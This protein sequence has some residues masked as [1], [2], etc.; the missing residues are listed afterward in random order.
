MKDDSHIQAETTDI[1]RIGAGV[2]MKGPVPIKKDDTVSLEI[3]DFDLKSN[4]QVIWVQQSGEGGW[5]AGLRF[6]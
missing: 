4:A 5:R 3:E 1:S 2:V 6:F